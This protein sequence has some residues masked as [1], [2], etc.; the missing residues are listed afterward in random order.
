MLGSSL[1]IAAL[2]V[3]D[4]AYE[5]DTTAAAD[6]ATET[7]ELTDME[8]NLRQLPTDKPGQYSLTR[9]AIEQ[10]QPVHPQELFAPIPGVWIS[11]GSGQ[12]HLTAIRSPVLTGAGAC[13]A[14]LMLE[15]NVPIRPAGFCN[16]NQLFEVNLVDAERVSV[17][18]GPGLPQHGANA[19]FGVIDVQQPE[20]TDLP[21][22][23]ASFEV[24]SNHFFRVRTGARGEH[25]GIRVNYTDS[26]SFRD[27]E[28][29]E[30]LFVE[31]NDTRRI[32][33]ARVTTYLNTAYLDQETAGF[34]R[35]FEAYL[36]DEAR[37]S[38]PNPEAFREASAVRLVSHWQW[39]LDS[40]TVLNVTPFGR[41]SRM[42]FLQ[43]F[44]P[45]QPLETNGQ[46]GGGVQIDWQRFWTTGRFD[47]QLAVGLDIEGFS[48]FLDEFQD[49]PVTFGSAFLQETRPAGAHY[50]YDVAGYSASQWVRYV[51]DFQNGIQIDTGLRAQWLAYDYTN[52]LL[53]GNTRDDGTECGFGGCL[54]TRPADRND[55]FFDLAPSFIISGPLV[56]QPTS[57]IRW[58]ARIAQGFR[59]PQATEL[60]RLQRGQSIA[61]L[62]SERSSSF[63]IGLEGVTQLAGSHWNYA[64]TGFYQFT[65]D[66]IF[67]NADG[68]NI[69]DGAIRSV[70]VEWLAEISITPQ[71]T[72]RISG[73][74]ADHEY[75]S[76]SFTGAGETLVAGNQV[77]TAPLWQGYLQLDWTPV[78]TVLLGADL[79]LLDGYFLNAANT[80][81]YTGH[82]LVHL[83]GS[84]QIT[85]HWRVHARWRNVFNN[86][87]AERA[88]FAFGGFR[89][90]PG[91]GSSIF[92]GISWET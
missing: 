79:E 21:N 89:Y 13:G 30:Q 59:P 16:V 34:I 88:D 38:N 11:R 8:V 12:E 53:D 10:R 84:W 39:Q 63:A 66:Q 64:I 32:G 46:T 33:S 48:G 5:P 2:L 43:H 31:L 54:F 52:N 35:G 1:L 25:T 58:Q 61:D 65:D 73:T 67:R 20:I 37:T 6:Q 56:S 19:L 50:D 24:G 91:Q 69:S 71:L 7:T 78:N 45:G 9:E 51:I 22:L 70:G 68:F 36:D 75:R 47:Q 60:Y 15:H 80:A 29:Y 3:T 42:D 92:V 90:F 57:D 44:L 82:G 49:E 41:R 40:Q 77:D 26:S 86:R 87:Y 55:D 27:D 14:F 74:Y 28:G 18:A 17:L 72:G 81:R 76:D 4:T 62:S 23:H 83:R 85:P